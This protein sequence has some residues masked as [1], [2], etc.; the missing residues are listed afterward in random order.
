MA[1]ERFSPLDDDRFYVVGPSKE[2][3]IYSIAMTSFSVCT[4]SGAILL[5]D[6]IVPLRSGPRRGSAV[7][8]K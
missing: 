6:T 7:S 5:L 3:D 4:S 1:P 8:W 2:S